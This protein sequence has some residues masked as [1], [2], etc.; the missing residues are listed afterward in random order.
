MN[1]NSSNPT[2]DVISNEKA[3][4]DFLS[5][6]RDAEPVAIDTEADSLH[7]YFEKLCLIQISIENISTHHDV[8]IDP[9]AGFSLAPLFEILARKNLVLHGVDYDLRL[10]RRAG[11][12]EIPKN[13]FDTMIAARLTGHTE[14]S[15]AALLSKYFG[16]ELAKA[17]QKANWAQRPLPEKMRE[18]AMNDTRHLLALARELE[19]QLREMNRWEWFEQSCAKAVET[20]KIDRERDFE[21][22]WRISGSAEFQGRAAAILRALWRWRDDEARAVDRPAFHILHNE[23]LIESTRR[24]ERGERVSIPHLSSSRARRFFDAADSGMQCAPELWPKPLRKPR[25]RATKEQERLFE[26]LK[27]RRDAAAA[28][29]KLDPALIAP[30]SALENLSLNPREAA[31][32]LLPWQREILEPIS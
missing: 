17:S 21:N 28:E 31:S 24:F 29:L 25:I 7:C 8:L 4:S 27:A 32:I 3:L 14:F 5:L 13:I 30:R 9:L 10:L 22:A 2:R 12:A 26:K 15:L 11:F 20:A 16:V 19:R 1:C 6:L 18:Y 23:K